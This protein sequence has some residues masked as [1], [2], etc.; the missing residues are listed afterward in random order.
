WAQGRWR[1]PKSSHFFTLDD[2][3]DGGA[4]VAATLWENSGLQ[5][6]DVDVPQVYD[7]FSPFVYFWLEA[8]GYCRRGEAFRFVREGGIRTGTTMNTGMK[9]IITGKMSFV[10]SLAAC[11]STPC[12][13]RSRSSADWMRSV[14]AIVTP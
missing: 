8:L 1:S 4:H 5:R 14:S 3:L 12:I 13:R 11:S 9:Q 7:G 10:D 2:M 6:H